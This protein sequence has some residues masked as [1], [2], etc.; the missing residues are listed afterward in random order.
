MAKVKRTRRRGITRISA[1]NQ[2]TIPVDAL[3]EAGLKPG[4]E[5]LVETN[6]AGRLTLIRVDDVIARFA[7]DMTGIY[8]PGYLD[9][10]RDEWR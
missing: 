9:K 10:L 3:R 6:G 4:D 8:T 1:K 5:L 2:I 7:G